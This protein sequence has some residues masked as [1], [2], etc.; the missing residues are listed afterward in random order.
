LA[1]LRHDGSDEKQQSENTLNLATAGFFVIRRYDRGIR[2][3]ALH[4]YPCH[5]AVIPELLTPATLGFSYQRLSGET[6]IHR[7]LSPATR[8]ICM[9]RQ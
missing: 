9:S 7:L 4:Q 3:D 8:V 2:K 1:E 6:S 5:I